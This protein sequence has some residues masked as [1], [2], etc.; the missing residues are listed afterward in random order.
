M[1]DR[2][3]LPRCHGF[4]SL[5]ETRRMNPRFYEDFTVGEAIQS[6]TYEAT[7]EEIIWFAQRYDPQYYHLDAERAGD[8][9]FGG[10]V[11]GGFQTAALAWGLAL[12]T[13]CFEGT[14]V[15]GIGVDELR[16]LRPLRLGDIVH[17]EFKLIDGRPSKSRPGIATTRFRYDVINQ[18]REIVLSATFIQMIKCRNS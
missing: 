16:W 18:H 10:L 8:S 15:A 7:S 13:G 1:T 14:A 9:I 3:D 6:P 12:R 11:A 4:E 2:I 5:P 17:V